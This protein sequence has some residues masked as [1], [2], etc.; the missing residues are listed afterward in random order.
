MKIHAFLSRTFLVMFL[1]MGI[2]FASAQTCSGYERELEEYFYNFQPGTNTLNMR[3]VEMVYARCPQPTPKMALVYYY[4]KSMDI[5]Y[6]DYLSDEAAYHDARYF[7]EKSAAYFAYLVDAPE[8]ESFFVNLYFDRAQALQNQLGID[9]IAIQPLPTQTGQTRGGDEVVEPYQFK[10]QKYTP[11]RSEGDN[12]TYRTRGMAENTIDQTT[13]RKSEY[14]NGEYQ[15][16]SRGATEGQEIEGEAYGAVGS[17]GSLNAY[18]YLRFRK[19]WDKQ[20]QHSEGI[21]DHSN[22]TSVSRGDASN[23][24]MAGPTNANTSAASTYTGLVCI[25]DNAV[26]RTNPGEVAS[27]VGLVRFGE[28]VAR[29]QNQDPV[30]HAGNTYYSVRLQ[31]GQLGWMV[32]HALVQDGRVAVITETAKGYLSVNP[33]AARDRNMIVFVA[34]ELV[35]LEGVKGDY[36]R[37]VSRD[38]QKRA[39]VRGIGELSIDEMDI[40]I[41]E[42]LHE[43]SQQ[44]SISMRK[45]ILQ[46]IR[47]LPGFEQ[48]ELADDVLKILNDSYSMR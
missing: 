37:I 35:V 15:E 28:T 46:G 26:V 30:Q 4:L 8:K 7:Y 9:Q 19:D 14:H 18:D 31:S 33:Q 32:S 2:S 22:G 17:L 45:A 12:S 21:V 5:W 20:T 11:A 38:A 42:K 39:W 27:P 41:G 6:A 36:I 44:N 47:N 13:L 16:V 3:Q 10:W 23:A 43:A 40:M 34:G 25:Y 29:L 48:S 1:S 24:R